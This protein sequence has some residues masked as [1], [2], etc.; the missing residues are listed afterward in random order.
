MID[1]FDTTSEVADRI[2][3][4]GVEGGFEFSGVGGLTIRFALSELGP[5]G[6]FL[7]AS[8]PGGIP[9]DPVF[10]QIYVNDFAGGVEFFKSLPSIDDPEELR[11]PDFQVDSSMDADFGWPACR[12]VSISMLRFNRIPT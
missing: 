2:L 8:V 12:R 11:N 3:F 9:I 7:N 10:T 5:L 6:V 1:P 4:F